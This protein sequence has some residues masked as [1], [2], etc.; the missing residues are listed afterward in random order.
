MSINDLV[1]RA[2][3]ILAETCAP[4]V[5]SALCEKLA[6]AAHRTNEKISSISKKKTPSTE[7]VDVNAV[8]KAMDEA[9]VTMADPNELRNSADHPAEA[10]MYFKSD[11]DINR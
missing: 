5:A 2:V 3:D 9:N 1:N 8:K 10:D 11:M 6:D 4:D 7:T